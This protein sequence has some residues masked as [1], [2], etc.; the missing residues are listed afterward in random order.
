MNQ[1]RK[2]PWITYLNCAICIALYLFECVVNHGP[3]I[4]AY[5]SATLGGSLP[6]KALAYYPFNGNLQKALRFVF[7]N[8][9]NWTSMWLHASITHI[10]CNMAF[11]IIIGRLIEPVFGH[12]RFFIIYLISGIFGAAAESIFGG[13]TVSIGASTALFGLLGAGIA[14]GFEI[15]NPAFS[16]QLIGLLIANLVLDVF[17]VQ[18]AIMGHVGGL[19]I[20]LILG[21]I[22][23]PRIY[24]LQTGSSSRMTSLW[25]ELPI[26][27]IATIFFIY[28]V[29]QYIV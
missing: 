3:T 6:A 14:L 7:L 22:L 1:K 15:G 12:I 8:K 18:I 21:Y 27:C 23:R 24:S 4:T 26:A 29:E 11:L 19:V 16:K 28:C 10:V 20:G 2:K 13:N 17:S 5:T 25:V 9:C